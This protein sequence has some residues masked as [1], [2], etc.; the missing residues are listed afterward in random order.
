[1]KIQRANEPTGKAYIQPER[2]TIVKATA[3]VKSSPYSIVVLPV[4]DRNPLIMKIIHPDNGCINAQ[5][6]AALNTREART[7][8]LEPLN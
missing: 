2:V 5:A 8:D 3:P 1:M 7:I 4:W 6:A